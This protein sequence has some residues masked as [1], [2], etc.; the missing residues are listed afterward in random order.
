MTFHLDQGSNF[1][2]AERGEFDLFSFIFN[3]EGEE[4]EPT[5]EPHEED[6]PL[7]D[8]TVDSDEDGASNS[9]LA[10]F[11]PQSSRQPRRVQPSKLQESATDSK[12]EGEEER[13]GDDD[14]SS[15]EEETSSSKRRAVK[16]RTISRWRKSNVHSLEMMK[17][18]Q[19]EEKDKEGAQCVL[20]FYRDGRKKC[21]VRVCSRFMS[22]K[23]R[24]MS[25]DT[26]DLS[27]HMKYHHPNEK[28]PG[29]KITQYPGFKDRKISDFVTKPYAELKRTDPRLAEEVLAVF[30]LPQNKKKQKVHLCGYFDRGK[31]NYF[32]IRTGKVKGHMVR[33]HSRTLP[34][35]KIVGFLEERERTRR[36]CDQM[37]YAD[38]KSKRSKVADQVLKYYYEN[39]F[40][41]NVHLCGS[42]DYFSDLSATITYENKHSKSKEQNEFEER[43][44]S[45]VSGE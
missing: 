20:D 30:K 39:K 2:M 25:K 31:C 22:G 1:T 10:V 29:Y 18:N 28:H 45:C 32:S 16:T 23:C 38:L 17:F 12:Y 26:R 35:V 44:F 40:R 19:L 13:D 27:R 33:K 7:V 43:V 24:Y 36:S 34:M 14:E 11:Q 6:S 37:T 21:C 8:L 9:T 5:T 42:C 4:D 3:R 41:G 15:D